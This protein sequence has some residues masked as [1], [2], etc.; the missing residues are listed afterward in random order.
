M[1]GVVVNYRRGRHTVRTNQIIVHFENINSREEAS[2]LIGKKILWVSPGKRK[3]FIGKITAPHGNKGNIRVAFRRGLPGQIIGDVV[4]LV[5]SP[6]KLK[7]L[8]EKI[9]SA[10]D[11][12]QVRKLLFEFFKSS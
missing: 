8:Q 9:K 10:K 5:D 1:I 12:N 6:E 3:F 4:F 11:I 7:E 2:K